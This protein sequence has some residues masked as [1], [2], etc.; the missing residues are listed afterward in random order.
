M[1]R[2]VKIYFPMLKI[3]HT[4]ELQYLAILLSHKIA[5]QRAGDSKHK[6]K[7]LAFSNINFLRKL[8]IQTHTTRG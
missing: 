5:Y 3:R 7:D 1:A 2:D 8:I 6:N 4:F